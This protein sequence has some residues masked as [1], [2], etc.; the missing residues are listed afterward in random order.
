MKV[1]K[2]NYVL[3]AVLLALIAAIFY[4][5]ALTGNIVAV[6]RELLST[7]DYMNTYVQVR[8]NEIYLVSG[9]DA[10]VMSTTPDQAL[11]VRLGLENLTGPRP[12]THDLVKDIFDLLGTGVI[13][14]KVEKLENSTYYAR[15][16]LQQGSKI[17]NLDSRPSDA[18]AISVRYGR[19]VFVRKE[20][21]ESAGRKVC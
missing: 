3:V 14:V 20:L 8:E 11:S 16:F 19:P 7:E 12:V 18:V 13:M 21:M 6:T 10:I 9:C 5:T 17:L 1:R 2:L 4:Q 15:L